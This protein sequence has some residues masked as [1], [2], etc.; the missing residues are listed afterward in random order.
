MKE[1]KANKKSGKKQD[2]TNAI[3]TALMPLAAQLLGLLLKPETQS[4]QKLE[5]SMP[6]PEELMEFVKSG[7]EL[8][9]YSLEREKKSSLRYEG[10]E[11]LDV[12]EKFETVAN[13]FYP[14]FQTSDKELTRPQIHEKVLV[15]FNNYLLTSKIYQ[16]SE[17]EKQYDLISK[18]NTEI[19]QKFTELESQMNE[20]IMINNMLENDN[21]SLKKRL[22]TEK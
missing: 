21:Q 13:R 19:I 14:S 20:Q 7:T 16:K 11:N 2:S 17:I 8:I 6:I 10:F 4:S 18:E 22:S 12:L 5:V 1:N 15:Q 9:N 3:I